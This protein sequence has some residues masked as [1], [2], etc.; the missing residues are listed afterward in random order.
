MLSS[1]ILILSY[2]RSMTLHLLLSY[3]FRHFELT[4]PR[5]RLIAHIQFTITL[6]Y[7]QSVGYYQIN[8]SK[9][10]CK[11]V[12]IFFRHLVFINLWIWL[13]L[14]SNLTL[15]LLSDLY[16]W[17]YIDS[18]RCYQSA[19][20]LSSSESNR[21]APIS[22]IIKQNRCIQRDATSPKIHFSQ[23]RSIFEVQMYRR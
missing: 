19:L 17:P 8:S 15:C 16:L 3:G 5:R 1:R 11:I 21:M 2:K 7:I 23:S 9:L 10:H 20:W 13:T 6:Q 22:L 12:L 4:S 18:I 14:F